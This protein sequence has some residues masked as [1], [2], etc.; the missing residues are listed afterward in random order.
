MALKTNS[1]VVRDRIQEYIR[2]SV[3][4]EEMEG[5]E[6]P[7]PAVAR[8]VMDSFEFYCKGKTPVYNMQIYFD[9]WLTGLPFGIGDFYLGNMKSAK[10]ILGDILE[11]TE[12]ERNRFTNEQAEHLLSS[13]IY[14][15]L[16][17]GIRD[18]DKHK[19]Y[20]KYGMVDLCKNGRFI[21]TMTLEK[22]KEF[23]SKDMTGEYEY[24]FRK[25]EIH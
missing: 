6:Y 17:K 10:D 18:F 23:I 12:E 8:Y 1:E 4:E 19:E 3:S 22:A 20:W 16:L 9:E 2:E 14:R 24:Y 11:E 13:L 5:V 25:R 21:E 15:E 7:F